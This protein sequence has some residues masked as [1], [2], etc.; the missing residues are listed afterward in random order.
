MNL[1]YKIESNYK[2]HNFRTDREI[3]DLQEELM[4]QEIRINSL[5]VYRDSEQSKIESLS[6]EQLV[7]QLKKVGLAEPI[8][9][10]SYGRY[11]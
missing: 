8:L 4:T 11:I 3:H 2:L 10:D 6:N 5:E 9:E 1:I 7:N